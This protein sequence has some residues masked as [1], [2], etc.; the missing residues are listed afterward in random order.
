MNADFVQSSVMLITLPIS[1]WEVLPEHP[2]Y[3]MIEFVTGGNLLRE[4]TEASRGMV[5]YWT[6]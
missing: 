5:G 4:N 6:V 3:K 1:L 2:A